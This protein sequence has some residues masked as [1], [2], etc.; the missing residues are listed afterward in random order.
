METTMLVCL[1][2]AASLL[3]EHI[4]AVPIN[5]E[6]FGLGCEREVS[7]KGDN[8]YV[9]IVFNT[10]I[11]MP[12]PPGTL[13]NKDLCDCDHSSAGQIKNTPAVTLPNTT[14]KTTP[15]TTSVSM[16]ATPKQPLVSKTISSST[17]KSSTV[18]TPTTTTT[19]TS[20]T[21]ATT[22]TTTEMSSTEK[23][24]TMKPTTT[25][26]TTVQTTTKT[27]VTSTTA[28]P[29]TVYK[30]HQSETTK[31]ATKAPSTTGKTTPMDV[32]L[33]TESTIPACPYKADGNGFIENVPG[34]GDIYSECGSG[35][36]F[37]ATRCGCVK[38]GSITGT[39]T[40][41]VTTEIV[42]PYRRQG[43]GYVEDIPGIGKVW[44]SCGKDELFMNAAC[45][46]VSKEYV[47]GT[48]PT[49]TEKPSTTPATPKT[50]P[51][52]ITSTITT[53]GNIA[54][55]NDR[56]KEANGYKEYNDV[57]MDWVFYECSASWVFSLSRCDCVDP[58][59]NPNPPPGP[60]KDCTNFEIKGTG[61][62]E[63]IPNVGAVY[64]NCPPNQLFSLTLCE[65][66][67][68]GGTGGT[69]GNTDIIRITDA[70]K[71]DCG[72]VAQGDGYTENI[73]GV[74]DVYYTC[75]S[76]HR[77]V[78]GLC[79]C[80]DKGITI[81][82]E[83]SNNA[84]PQ[85]STV[86][87]STAVSKSD[88]STTP[89]IVSSTSVTD[90]L[91]CKDR[92][93]SGNGYLEYFESLSD[94]VFFE[95][96]TT[97]EFSIAECDCV[98]TGRH[99][100]T[101]SPK[102]DCNIEA[103]G[104]GFI[105]NIPGVG[106]V[107]SDCPSTQI[108]Y[109]SLCACGAPGSGKNHDVITI[110]DQN[111][112]RNCAF[113]E[114][115]DGFVEHVVGVGLVYHD[116]PGSDRFVSALCK[117]VD[118]DT[119]IVDNSS[120]LKTTSAT[121]VTPPITTVTPPPPTGQTVTRKVTSTPPPITTVTPSTTTNQ[122]VTNKDCIYEQVP[123]EKREFR[124]PMTWMPGQYMYFSCNIGQEFDVVACSCIDEKVTTT[125]PIINT[126]CPF[127]PSAIGDNYFR[128]LLFGIGWVEFSCAMGQRY[129]YSKCI[130]VTRT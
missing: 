103:K 69:G 36:V 53:P 100:A 112:V 5:R 83:T 114:R 94:W 129:D 82:D 13:Y 67:G 121:K 9:L 118:K 40:P 76:N 46:C 97:Q 38:K 86:S 93:K 14:P 127:L 17:T 101:Q 115:G 71:I 43:T 80:I 119:K 26:A 29:P 54:R 73:L 35:L 81:I 42:C 92:K 24:T 39:T 95:C 57:I 105:E 65:C 22:P 47:T 75:V 2:L 18:K 16:T 74:G 60:P 25:T 84:V 8:Y 56:I 52:I 122:V 66:T 62:I 23:T 11:D 58:G 1:V 108:F 20:T 88:I 102:T 116:C 72:F 55:C 49:T 98:S 96:S 4:L 126:D 107:Y 89:S 77:F 70:N 6:N 128:F 41:P 61:Y 130:C 87:L 111:R 99:V 117:C 45:Q 51:V 44:H 19:A 113:E 50:T 28:E 90:G 110:T 21:R 125:Q 30:T 37:S 104:N 68:S 79:R 27:A 120:P 63:H 15:Q 32:S 109:S 10:K 124:T 64:N 85:S 34:F 123:G 91:Q 78:T 48:E 33:S 106:A 3:P 59:T 31:A 12:C 7:T